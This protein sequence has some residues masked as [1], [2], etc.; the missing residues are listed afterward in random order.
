MPEIKGC[1]TCKWAKGHYCEHPGGSDCGWIEKLF[2]GQPP[3]WND[4]EPRS[5]ITQEPQSKTQIIDELERTLT[6]LRG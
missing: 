6:S 3:S 2:H 1:E 4:W 5:F